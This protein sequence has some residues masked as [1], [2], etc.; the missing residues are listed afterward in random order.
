MRLDSLRRVSAA[1]CLGFLGPVQ[2]ILLYLI[3]AQAQLERKNH[4][5]MSWLPGPFTLIVELD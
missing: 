2:S 4:R 5:V 1:L 3:T